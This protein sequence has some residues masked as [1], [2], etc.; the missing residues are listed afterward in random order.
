MI[1]ILPGFTPTL[2][3]S[4]GHSLPA[5]TTTTPQMQSSVSFPRTRPD[6]IRDSSSWLS[7]RETRMSITN[8]DVALEVHDLVYG[9]AS[10]GTDNTSIL[11][12]LERLYEPNASES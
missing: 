11:A 1:V 10:T 3:E 2:K 4:S 8:R 12:T 5:T 7:G 6:S 9:E